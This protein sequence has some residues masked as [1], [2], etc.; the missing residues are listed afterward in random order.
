MFQFKKKFGNKNM[1]L[2]VILKIVNLK[3]NI[4]IPPPGLCLSLYNCVNFCTPRLA[5][6]S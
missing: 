5:Q 2:D 3:K 6:F 4:N 1:V